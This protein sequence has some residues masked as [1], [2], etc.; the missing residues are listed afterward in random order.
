MT[1]YAKR[2]TQTEAQRGFTLIEL[3]IVVAILAVLL[4]VAVPSYMSFDDSARESVAES[5]VR[6]I[7]PAVESFYSDHSSYSAIDNAATGSPPG[8]ASYDP[9]GSQHVVIAS[10]SLNT[11]CLYSTSGTSTF[12]KKGPGGGITADPGPVRDDCDAS[13]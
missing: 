2:L 8:L 13:T 6:A 4:A 1:R 10:A 5:N 9:S 7:V 3:L 11:Y 12:F